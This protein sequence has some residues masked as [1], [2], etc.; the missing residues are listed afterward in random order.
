MLSGIRRRWREAKFDKPFFVI[1]SIII[2]VGL[3]VFTSAALS[4]LAKNPAQ[5][6]RILISQYVLGLVG[7]VLVAYVMYRVPYHF[8]RKYAFYLFGAALV[9]TALVFIPGLSMSHGGATRWLS[10]G[11]VSFQPAELLKIGFVIYVAAWYAWAKKRVTQHK[12]GIIPLGIMLAVVGGLLLAQPDTGTFLVIAGTAVVMYFVSGARLRDL[13]IILV[14]AIAMG[15]VLIATRPYLKARIKTFINPAHDP[16]GV[17]YQLRQSLIA[18]GSGQ[19]FGRGYG[20]SVQKVS[21]LP[22]PMGDSVFA[23]AAE[24]LGFVGSVVIIVLYLAFVLRGL[25]IARRAPNLFTQLLVTGLVML[26]IIQAFL[27]IASIVGVFPLTG[28]PLIFMSQ[29]GTALLFALASVGI[30]LHVSK[31]I[32]RPGVKQRGTSRSH[33]KNKAEEE[34]SD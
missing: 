2:I 18:I 1:V 26:V 32:K 33:R 25:F 11:P 3:F 24:E 16:Q 22:E 6:Y 14:L 31:Y 8:W 17:S 12:F 21:Y 15:G 28:L 4:V 30:I 13:A 19:T 10:I 29:G 9:I 23:V 7:G 5:F 34:K 27:N 20:L